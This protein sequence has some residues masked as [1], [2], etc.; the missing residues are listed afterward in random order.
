MRRVLLTLATVAALTGCSVFGQ[1]ASCTR[2]DR[3]SAVSV[4]WRPA[5]FGGTDAAVVR[6]CVEDGCEERESGDA[7]DP[8]A[9]VSVR[10]PD[11]IGAV[12][13]PVRLK[14]TT[15]RDDRIVV[16]A[17]RRARLTEQHP[18]GTSCAPGAWTATFRADPD[19][20]LTSPEGLSLR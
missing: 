10:L 11:D 17:G 14:V 20:G 6:V 15:A 16:D 8:V 3:D 7:D 19:K 2:A 13:V 4:V 9:G 5:D 12:T 18:N 1:N